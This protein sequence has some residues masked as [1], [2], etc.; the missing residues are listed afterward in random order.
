MNSKK[1]Q[2]FF[3]NAIASLVLGVLLGAFCALAAKEAGMLILAGVAAGI[4]FVLGLY[5][6]Y[7]GLGLR[8]IV[9]ILVFVLS[10]LL[11]HAAFYDIEKIAIGSVIQVAGFAFYMC[12]PYV[13]LLFFGLEF[14]RDREVTGR[15]TKVAAVWL[16]LL[17]IGFRVEK[18]R[19]EK[20]GQEQTNGFAVACC[21]TSNE[22]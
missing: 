13:L 8:G 3:L 19:I 2:P 6:F 9:A 7:K 10:G 15:M 12:S 5:P 1:R 17:F 22:G 16:L 20:Q 11:Y 14:S 4:L 18:A 21:L